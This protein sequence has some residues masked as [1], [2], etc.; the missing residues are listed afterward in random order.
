V[1]GWLAAFV[2]SSLK[3]E[4]AS[5]SAELVSVYGY[6]L[7]HMKKRLKSVSALLCEL[8]ISHS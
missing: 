5:F 3:V 8:E 7:H 4:A 1:D 2:L 6:T